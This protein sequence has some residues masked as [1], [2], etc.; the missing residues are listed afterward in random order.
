[1][2]IIII[3]IIIVIIIVG[4]NLLP[5][6]SQILMDSL[7]APEFLHLPR[8]LLGIKNNNNNNIK[9][10]PHMKLIDKLMAAGTIDL[11]SV[12]YFD[13]YYN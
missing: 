1:M 9:S 13:N 2:I 10:V 7:L 6:A 11:K 4:D 8:V 12:Y 3:Y 5:L